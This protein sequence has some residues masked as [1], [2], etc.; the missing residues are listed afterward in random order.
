MCL[1]RIQGAGKEYR[2]ATDY[3]SK[4]RVHDR[5]GDRHLN[6]TDETGIFEM[7]QIFCPILRGGRS[8]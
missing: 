8:L 4:I 5:G 1:N 7:N 3:V 2:L 6:K